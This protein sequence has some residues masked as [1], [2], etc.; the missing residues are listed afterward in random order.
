[1]TEIDAC[2]DCA[3]ARK[4]RDRKSQSR[5]KREKRKEGSTRKQV[6]ENPDRR[7]Y[8]ENLM[9]I[10]SEELKGEKNEAEKSDSPKHHTEKLDS[11]KAITTNTDEKLERRKARRREE[12]RPSSDNVEETA[13]ADAVL[14]DK[15]RQ[16]L[17][18]CNRDRLRTMKHVS[19]WIRQQH[20]LAAEF[21]RHV[22]GC[23][24]ATGAHSTAKRV[25]SVQHEHHHHYHIY[26]HFES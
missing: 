15:H 16:Q 26:H 20:V 24:E 25:V 14:R 2:A 22:T 1:M 12:R 3:A 17:R 5:S 11:Q 23:D 19:A 18:R 4:H 8:Y 21:G 10:E 13:D 9:G 7:Q 6:E